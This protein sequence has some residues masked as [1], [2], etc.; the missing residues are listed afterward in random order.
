MI[1]KL[2]RSLDQAWIKYISKSK[3]LA[4]QG[5]NRIF[6]F[7]ADP[8]LQPNFLSLIPKAW[9]IPTRMVQPDPRFLTKKLLTPIPWLVI[10][11]LWSVIPD[12]IPLIPIP[13]L[14]IPGLRFLIPPFWSLIPWLVIPGLRFL[15]P[16]F[17]SLIPWLVI[18]GLRFLIPSF[19][20]LI[21]WLVIAGL[22]FLIPPF[23]SLIPWLELWSQTP[24]FWSHGP[25]WSLI[26]YTSLRLRHCDRKFDWHAR[27]YFSFQ[28]QVAHVF[29]GSGGAPGIYGG[30]E[31]SGTP[32]YVDHPETEGLLGKILIL[33]SKPRPLCLLITQRV[34]I[35]PQLPSKSSCIL[36]F[37][38]EIWALL[39]LQNRRFSGE[40]EAPAVASGS[41]SALPRARLRV[42]LKNAGWALLGPIIS[43]QNLLILH[44][45]LPFRT[46]AKL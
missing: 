46:N 7:I 27:C 10:P 33:A 25:R 16:P 45:F 34:L 32:V 30:K 20:S 13:W 37:T 18:A 39:S 11:D 15:I 21:P 9:K 29:E 42:C 31:G 24:P 22:R 6:C 28:G 8:I 36:R 4:F 38:A 12:L 14:V 26:P 44:L 41:R 3:V 19:W 43:I 5:R 35:V 17:W 23:W 40:R 2:N 1:F